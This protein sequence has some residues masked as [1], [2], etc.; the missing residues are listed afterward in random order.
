MRNRGHGR[1]GVWAVLSAA[2]LLLFSLTSFTSDQVITAF[3]PEKFVRGTGAPQRITRTFALP[4]R[5]DN[6]CTLLVQNGDSDKTRVTSATLT[7]DGASVVRPA[8]FKKSVAQIKKAVVLK[9]Q[10]TLTVELAGKPS[11]FIVVSVTC[12]PALT[13]NIPPVA[14]AGPDQT[15][16]VGTTVNLDGSGSSDAN[17]DTLTYAWSFVSRPTGS[18]ATLSGAAT[19][20]PSFILDKAGTYVVQLIVNDGQASSTADRVII[21]TLNSAPVA[22][23][24]SDQT[25]RMTET[26]ILDGSGSTDI[27]GNAL[28]YRWTLPTKPTGSAA[29]LNDSARVDP[30]FVVD[31]AG[32]Y[33]AQLTVNDGAVDSAPDS[34][35]VTTENSPPVA[36]AGP[37]RSVRVAE[38]VALDGSGSTDVDGDSLTYQWS[39]TSIPAGSTASLTELAVPRPAFVADK[40]G[41]YV[42]QL[43]VHDGAVASAPDTVTIS[44]LNTKPVAEAGPAQTVALNSVVR[45]D[46]GGSADADGDPLTYQWAL[47]TKPANSSATLSDATV[48]DPSFIAD[49]AGIY[50]AQLIVNDG[51]LDSDPDTVTI[52]TANSRPVANA[53]PDQQKRI[54]D[55]VALDGSA[56]VDTDGGPLAYRWSL[57]TQ[58]DGSAATLGNAEQVQANF[59]PD[60]AGDYV[61]QLIVN[62]GTLDSEPDSALV[63]VT[64]STPTNRAPEIKSSPVTTAT[65]GQ[66]YSYDVDATDPDAGDKL[67][68]SLSTSL[69]GMTIDAT[70][71]LIQWTPG[72]V[73]LANVV[74][75]VT[76]L[77]GLFDEQN[78]A[79]TISAVP[80]NQAPTVDAG[81]PQTITLPGTANLAGTVTDDGLPNPPGAVTLA[82]SQVN[83]PGT[84]SFAN[85]ANATTT[86]TFSSAGVYVLRLTAT[87]SALS[88]ND[89]VQITVNLPVTLPPDPEDVAPDIDPTVATTTFAATEFLYTGSNPIQTGVAPGTIDPKRA[90]VM[91]GR[92]LDRAGQPISGVTLTILN[93][94]EFGQTLSRA[95]GGFDLA[96]NGGGYLTLN[97]QRN[98]YLPAQRQKNVPLQ[99]YVVLEDVV[100]ITRDVQATVVDLT[101]S[102]EIQVARGSQVSDQSGARQATLLIPPGTQAQVYNPDGTTRT[103]TSLTLRASEFT[104]GANGPKAMPGPLPANVAYTY[105]LELSA[106]EATTKLNG[107]DVLFNQ[108]VPFYVDNFL[109][110]PAGIDAP[111]GYYDTDRGAWVPDQSG[112][113]INILSITN[114]RANLG[115][116]RQRATGR[117]RR[118]RGAGHHRRRTRKTRQPLLRWQEFVAGTAHAPLLLGYQLGLGTAG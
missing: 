90:A 81:S 71:G 69:D 87:D 48:V 76:D 95:D 49:K 103:V 108:P 13:P 97:Y 17:G 114:G 50:A 63:T 109:N 26:A 12:P 46:G 85:L 83:G 102:N 39:L 29:T 106:D 9:P 44:T 64:A 25:A 115:R 57:T 111:V 70:T 28:T 16:T 104:V 1:W 19:F 68:Y 40:S 91:R 27:D 98:G 36:D 100:L 7:L 18:T 30:S 15:A 88:A 34:V 55:T 105:A 22:H 66:P 58:P 60:L 73:A 41:Q 45:L 107:K 24:G 8:D 52:S 101:N 31:K 35:T 20:N 38:T 80:T 113:V 56:S 42:A 94:P 112:R 23:A 67:T 96:V 110:F 61:A 21:S 2:F 3:G 54:G 93:H 77:G 117:C 79:I 65:V 75:R 74:V 116:D 62:D 4:S 11:S 82:W 78:Y 53:G 14:N 43:I 51:Q 92:V 99:D 84:V 59:M 37:D 47:P 118:P 72:Q 33:E 89:T 86:A 32:K 5:A 6:H 10:N